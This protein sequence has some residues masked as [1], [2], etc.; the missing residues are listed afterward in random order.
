MDWQP[1]N[2]LVAVAEKPWTKGRQLRRP[3]YSA[4]RNSGK[5]EIE[6]ITLQGVSAD[7]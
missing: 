5:E 4:K 6:A 1:T 3:S 7:P 2:A